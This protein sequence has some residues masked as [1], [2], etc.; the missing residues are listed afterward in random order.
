M[1]VNRVGKTVGPVALLLLLVLLLLP[2]QQVC[3]LPRAQFLSLLFEPKQGGVGRVLHREKNYGKT[4]KYD[5][6]QEGGVRCDK[7]WL[8][9]QPHRDGGIGFVRMHALLVAWRSSRQ[10]HYVFARLA[11]RISRVLES[12]MYDSVVN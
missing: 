7:K 3:Q 12:G 8:Q 2:L 6:G 5:E 1:V 4:K 11:Y 9:A 10:Q